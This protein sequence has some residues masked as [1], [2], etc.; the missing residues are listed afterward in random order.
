VKILTPTRVLL[1]LVVAF[2][3]LFLVY[4]V[5]YSVR[6]AFTVRRL[7]TV[8]GR[9]QYVE[10]VSLSNFHF[11]Y[12]H[13]RRTGGWGWALAR[14]GARTLAA[15]ALVA[16]ILQFARPGPR[17]RRILMAAAA[18]APFTVFLEG[19]SLVA[20]SLRNSFVIGGLATVGAMALG[21]PLAWFFV[22]T[23]FAGR[24][25]LGTLLLAPM[26]MPPF[27]GAVGM[28]LL[29]SEQGPLNFL[30]AVLRDPGLYVLSAGQD[31]L[32][33]VI[34]MV[35][36]VGALVSGFGGMGGLG[37][38][39]RGTLGVMLTLER[40]VRF[41]DMGMAA[42]V[43]LEVLHL[44]PIIYMN[45][46]SS[47]AR[48]D[49]SMEESARSLGDHGLRLFRR[50]TLPMI[51]PGVFAGAS[52]VFI[53]AFTDLGTP[54]MLQFDRTVA[55]QIFRSLDQLDS[56]R[57]AYA[58]IMLILVMTGAVF[59][60]M[61]K[62]LGEEGYSGEGKG[63]AR[64]EEQVLGRGRAALIYGFVLGVIALALLPHL[65]VVLTSVAEPGS[66]SGRLLPGDLTLAHYKG[67][68]SHELT[69]P[70]V[71][72]SLI[73]SVGSTGLDIVLGVTIAWL[74]ARAAFRGRNLLDALVMLP[75]AL[76]GLVL[77]FGYMASFSG[78]EHAWAV[79]RLPGVLQRFMVDFVDPTRNPT[80]LLVISYA[81]RRLPYMVRAA[82]AGF[83]QTSVGLEEAS[84]SLG[85]GP[86]RTLWRVTLPLIAANLAG[87]TM[88]CFAF[89]MLEV[90]DSLILAQTKEYFPVAK[91]IYMLAGM[92]AKGSY[93]ACAFGVW[94]MVFLGLSL[95]LSSSFMGRKMGSLFR[96]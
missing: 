1:V 70:S 42:V 31:E 92:P 14:A 11:L 4:P 48:V 83:M 82:Y 36:A 94:A 43:G 24:N 2:L 64:I 63:A 30:L 60:I 27:V 9:E 8:A 81:V 16:L 45:V 51:L 74:L 78:L 25:T 68:L 32:G 53:W 69:L 37:A 93:Y 90:S 35:G 77:A 26:I 3:A 44:Y 5:L 22:R 12:D 59:L 95:L 23:R 61:R 88:L 58:L 33:L 47:L 28:R 62:S 57:F 84:A 50:V 20:E 13:I 85:A 7:E 72:R 89:S 87:G 66:W 6:E 19:E 96:V 52:I 29:L 80:I 67:A 76:P 75:L 65:S 91:S 21:L 17:A 40:P 56:N 79:R 55:V 73:Y 46:A 41:S 38:E 34:E 10:R 86:L 18:L 49:P 71:K 54:L 39:L 15:G